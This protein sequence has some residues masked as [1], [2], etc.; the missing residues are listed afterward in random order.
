MLSY[1]LTGE[2]QPGQCEAGWSSDSCRGRRWTTT[3]RND[4]KIAPS[5]PAKVAASICLESARR[6]SDLRATG[7]PA[8]TGALRRPFTSYHSP[9]GGQAP[10]P[11]VLHLR[12]TLPSEFRS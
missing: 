9:L 7:D 2:P 8:A 1:G 11:F 12:K 10:V 4:P 3:F 5:T 6:R